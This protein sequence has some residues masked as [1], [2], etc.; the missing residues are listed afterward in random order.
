MRPKKKIPL[1]LR[2]FYF[3][4][5]HIRIKVF[6]FEIFLIF[7]VAGLLGWILSINT[8][9]TLTEKAHQFAGRIVRD[10]SK[11]IKFDSIPD[12]DEAV[13][14]FK[15]TPGLVY[16]GYKGILVSGG[17]IQKTH[18]YIGTAPSHD[19]WTKMK[20]Y[21]ASLTNFQH[22]S[23]IISFGTNSAGQ[24]D[25][26]FEYY[27]P[28]TLKKLKNKKIGVIELRYSYSI[29]QKEIN[30]MRLLILVI[31]LIIII[32][33]LTLSF[34]GINNLVRPIIHLTH[35]VRLFGKGDL[36]VKM[37]V[38]S[39]DEI[40]ELAES[41]DEMVLSVREKLE[42]QK[43]VSGS[44]VKMIKE[45]VQKDQEQSTERKKV[46]MFFS[47]IRGFTSMSE[48]LDPQ[49]VV[50]ILNLFFDIQTEII[51]DNKGDID[52]YVGDEI[53]AVFE[54]ENM[55]GLAVRAA[56]EIQK[57]LKTLN[58]IRRADGRLVVEVGI[59]IHI[60]EVI[61]GSIGSSERKDY[62]VIGDSVNLSSRLCSA[63]G[64]GEIIVSKEV[65]ERLADKKGLKKLA[66]IN[67]KGKSKAIQ[68]FRVEYA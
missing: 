42:M 33:S 29:I 1:L 25:R 6:L 34:R 65:F 18:L 32:F 64:K 57:K 21:F 36:F 12:S 38:K 61:M 23:S 43:F 11:S 50:N 45:S 49:D 9:R 55:G 22:S 26:G 37:D 20:K 53:V 31:T 54:G 19:Y 17:S 60:G 66:P 44:T 47:D 28:V 15:G 2:P 30:K 5:S 27:M 16:L 56:I 46:A 62:T 7:F 13:H 63:A 67:V 3:L 58:E 10:L 24:A 35:L 14:D 41:F 52:K 39:I 4:M 51:R 40:G 68:V 59:G 8:E 48:N